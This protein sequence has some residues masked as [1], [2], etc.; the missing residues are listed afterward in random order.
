VLQQICCK[1]VPVASKA[2]PADHRKSLAQARVEA[3]EVA[4]GSR[5]AL[6][7]WIGAHRSQIT[8][9]AGGQELGGD[10]GWLLAS[11][12]AVV[13][14]LLGLLEPDAVPGWLHGNNPHLND[15]RP[16]DVLAAGDVAAVMA[17]IQAMRTGVFA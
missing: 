3:G 6:A 17:A 15:R 2:R 9:A 8:R 16:I 14:A 13:T 1:E 5:A 7:D 11:L 4:F 12:A 10:E